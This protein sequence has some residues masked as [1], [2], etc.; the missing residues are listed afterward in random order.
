MQ[1]VNVFL[2]WD[3]EVWPFDARFPHERL[4]KTKSYEA[5]FLAYAG[6]SSPTDSA[7]H[8]FNH[9]QWQLETLTQY[10]LKGIF[11]L[12]TMHADA[13][14][15]EFLDLIVQQVRQNGQEIGLHLHPEWSNHLVEEFLPEPRREPSPAFN[16]ADYELFTL[17]VQRGVAAL[18]TL[19][20]VK[21]IA[22]RAGSFL[23][24]PEFAQALYDS[25]IR[26]DLSHNPAI[27]DSCTLRR[28]YLRSL[29][30]SGESNK[31]PLIEIPV[32]TFTSKASRLGYLQLNGV[33]HE[34]MKVV[35]ESAYR[36]QIPNCVV[37]LHPFDFIRIEKA[38]DMQ[39]V[40]RIRQVENRFISLCKLLASR[41]DVWR[42]VH[43]TDLDQK[44]F[45]YQATQVAARPFAVS[46]AA[47]I[48]RNIGQAVARFY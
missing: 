13:I 32:T 22:F 39:G 15:G 48:R 18:E 40:D 31:T 36:Q 4:P 41:P 45:R 37:V 14:G 35:L 47:W 20:G 26:Y 17:M 42:T 24:R 16:E 46:N 1:P 23:M 34:I 21:P 12:E 33:S 29:T 7:S 25:G 10:G 38:R 11:F 8:G 5:E 44:A 27:P 28:N 3:C 30:A 2:T 19:V 43:C 6:R 9:F